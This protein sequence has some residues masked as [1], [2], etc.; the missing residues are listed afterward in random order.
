MTLAMR[1]VSPRFSDHILRNINSIKLADEVDERS[2]NR[3]VKWAV[4]VDCRM[5]NVRNV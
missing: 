3:L 4:E 2:F 5:K 1:V